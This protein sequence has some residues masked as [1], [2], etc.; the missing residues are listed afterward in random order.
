MD[1][2]HELV[3]GEVACS[4]SYLYQSII[5]NGNISIVEDMKEKISGLQCIMKH[6]S[7]KD[8]WD[9]NEKYFER[10]AVFK[11]V[12]TNLSCKEH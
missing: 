9:F 1:T 8:N 3:K 5:G 7:K 6:Y 2:K 4:Y 11:L 10:V 12:V